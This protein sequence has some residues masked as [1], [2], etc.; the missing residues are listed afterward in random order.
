MRVKVDE[1]RGVTAGRL[2]EI[3]QAQRESGCDGL[4]RCILCNAQVLSECCYFQGQRVFD[5]QWAVLKSLTPRQME[6][7]LVRL[8]NGKA[9][10]AANPNFDS[11]RFDALREG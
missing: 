7:L 2:L 11:G 3:W 9:A 6:A 4:E 8:A 5:S 1:L 10:S